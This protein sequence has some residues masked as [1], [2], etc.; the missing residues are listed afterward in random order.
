VRVAYQTAWEVELKG[1]GR[2]D[3]GSQSPGGLDLV[4]MIVHW[5]DRRQDAADTGYIGV[6]WWYPRFGV[7]WR[8]IGQIDSEVGIER[9]VDAEIQEE[10]H[11]ERYC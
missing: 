3:R 9:K 1:R 4:G 7:G 6:G 8:S 11:K 2:Q 10:D 5:G